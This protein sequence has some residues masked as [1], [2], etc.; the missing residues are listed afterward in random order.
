[1]KKTSKKIPIVH[2]ELVHESGNKA[3]FILTFFGISKKE[4]MSSGSLIHEALH[5]RGL[6]GYMSHPLLIDEVTY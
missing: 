5:R 1:M 3:P 2:V 6:T 4:F